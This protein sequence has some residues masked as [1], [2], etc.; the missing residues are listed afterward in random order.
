MENTVPIV[1]YSWADVDRLT[2]C[3]ATSLKAAD[4]RFDAI[5]GVLRGG[6]I[7]AVHL[8]HLMEVRS[9]GVV[10]FQTTLTDQSGSERI[11]P[12][13]LFSPEKKLI[14]GKRVLL[15]DDVVNTGVTLKAAREVLS[16]LGAISVYSAV[17]VWDRLS[18]EGG[19]LGTVQCDQ[20]VD[21]VTAW[22][23]F[24]WNN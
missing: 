13:Q 2:R 7:P 10:H 15:I 3:L 18:P 6:A 19:Q 1:R 21:E 17:L 16:D 8:S 23:E 24:P 5:V 20:W 14:S 9:F 12:V 4:L 11:D 22:V